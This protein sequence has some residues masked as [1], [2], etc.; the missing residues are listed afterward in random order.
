[1]DNADKLVYCK[2][3][4]H[5]QTEKQCD[6]QSCTN[7]PCFSCSLCVVKDTWDDCDTGVSIN[8]RKCY[9]EKNMEE[10]VYCKDCKHQQSSGECK[11]NF[12]CIGCHCFGCSTCV[13]SNMN[14]SD[15]G[16]PREK[17]NR[18]EEKQI[19]LKHCPFC[20]GK[21]EIYPFVTDMGLEGYR[22]CC[23]IC[24][25]MM[26]PYIPFKTEEIARER[27]NKRV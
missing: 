23:T 3:C 6:N 25:S 26:N 27:W 12:T 11:G 22:V 5:Q 10:L 20:G 16:L 1:M 14:E 19:E 13:R 7:C 9:E 2:D 18:Y 8:M 15:C 24:C 21:A 17:R 4:K